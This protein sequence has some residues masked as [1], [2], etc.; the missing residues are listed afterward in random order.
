M[1]S[2][3]HSIKH[4]KSWQTSKRVH[5]AWPLDM[6]ADTSPVSSTPARLKLRPACYRGKQTE[7]LLII[8]EI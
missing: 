2:I 3:E 4:M 5:V 8:D 7:Y 6:T 1:R